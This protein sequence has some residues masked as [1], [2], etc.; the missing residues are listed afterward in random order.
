MCY[1]LVMKTVYFIRHG[2]SVGNASIVRQQGRETHLSKKGAHQA[3][4]MALHLKKFHFEKIIASPFVRAKV[5]A[6]ALSSETGVPLTFSEL[7]IERRRPGIQLRKA[8]IHPRSVWAQLHLALFSRFKTYRYSDEETP[9]DLL[10]R[11]REAFTYLEA[12]TES[13]I[14]VVTHGQFMRAL[15]ADIT[16]GEGV[17]SRT[18]LRLTRTMRMHN[19]AL[20][21]ATYEEGKWSIKAWNVDAS[22]V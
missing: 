13:T 5:T 21:I 7:F 19:T 12:Q 4:E 1:L 10:K 20:M 3:K 8:K 14:A 17:T 6:E 16:L 22:V 11:A 18:Y 9:D 2:Q 15:Y